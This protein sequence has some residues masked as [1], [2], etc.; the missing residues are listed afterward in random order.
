MSGNADLRSRARPWV[1]YL[2]PIPWVGPRQRQ[3]D[4]ALQLAQDFRVLFVEPPTRRGSVRV[5]PLALE[6]GLWL[7]SPRGPLPLARVVSPLNLAT[8]LVVGRQLSRWVAAEDTPTV[9]WVGEDLAAACAGRCGEVA[10]IYDVADADWTFTRRW[11]RWHLRRGMK[12]ARRRADVTFASST[13]IAAA[14][15][16]SV[17]RTLVIPNACDPEHFRP[18]GPRASELDPTPRPILGFIGTAS[19]RALDIELLEGV[20]RARPDWSHVIVGRYEENVGHRLAAHDNVL[21]MGERPYESLPAF[22]RTFDVCTIPYRV[23]STID[24]VFPK[25]LLEYLAAGRP[26]VATPLPELRRFSPHVRL[27]ATVDDFVAAV[28]LSLADSMSGRDGPA[29]RARRAVALENTWDSR[30]RIIRR[31]VADLLE[32]A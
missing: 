26:V 30:G 10:V 24:Y 2:S 17:A 31:I 14:L 1:I 12:L 7:S 23:G 3:H 20:A 18:D 27:A 22:V 16:P 29:T 8:R 5:R 11:N 32:A 4:L 21:L 9:L 6:E 13:T 19:R 28:E 25:K 15:P